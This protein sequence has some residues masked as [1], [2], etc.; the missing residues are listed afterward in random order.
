MHFQNIKILWKP[1][2]IPDDDSEY[3]DFHL[4]YPQD[5][6]T[7]PT[8]EKINKLMEKITEKL[9]NDFTKEVLGKHYGWLDHPDDICLYSP[10]AIDGELYSVESYGLKEKDRPNF[11]NFFQ[12][13]EMGEEL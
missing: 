12:L 3:P 13:D 5:P 9:P 4:L 11:D 7:K 1:D 6:E 8:Q 10:F 2:Q